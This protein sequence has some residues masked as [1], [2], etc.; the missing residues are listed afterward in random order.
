MVGKAV[1]NEVGRSIVGSAVGGSTGSRMGKFLGVVGVS[2]GW[3]RERTKIPFLRLWELAWG[4]R[5]AWWD[6]SWGYRYPALWEV[7][8]VSPWGYRF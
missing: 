6:S 5:S 4:S 3:E 7:P 8:R 1:T 2:V